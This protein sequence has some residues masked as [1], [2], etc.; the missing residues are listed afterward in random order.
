MQ[1]SIFQNCVKMNDDKMKD[2]KYVI[3]KWF[4][5]DLDFEFNNNTTISS[6]K[7]SASTRFNLKNM[8]TPAWP[9]QN[10]AS[11]LHSCRNSESPLKKLT[12]RRKSRSGPNT[13]RTWRK[14]DAGLAVFYINPLANGAV[15]S[16]TELSSS[17]DLIP[18]PWPQYNPARLPLF[19]QIVQHGSEPNP[20]A[21]QH[22]NWCFTSGLLH[23]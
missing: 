10:L 18:K 20:A 8:S 12:D 19:T 13:T 3:W 9:K 22:T 2:F 5:N 15:V 4:K 1:A 16:P 21:L 17:F 7:N 23:Q 14:P 11:Q 6:K